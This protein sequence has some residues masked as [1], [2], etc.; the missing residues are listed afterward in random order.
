MEPGQDS[1]NGRN[2]L[3]TKR[4]GMGGIFDVLPPKENS[5]EDR[6]GLGTASCASVRTDDVK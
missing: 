6:Q 3:K 5:D 4:D 2:R 1:V